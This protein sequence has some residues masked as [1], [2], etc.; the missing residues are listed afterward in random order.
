MGGAPPFF[1]LSRGLVPSGAQCVSSRLRTVAPPAALVTAAVRSQPIG[2]L[3][4]DAQVVAV[5]QQHGLT[6]LASHDT[7]FDRVP[8]LTRYAPA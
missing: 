4:N 2:S 6:N 7:D 5:M 8:G 1:S 3:T